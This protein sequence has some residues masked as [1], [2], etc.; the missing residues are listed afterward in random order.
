MPTPARRPTYPLLRTTQL[1]LVV[2]AHAS[3]A[4]RE[5]VDAVQAELSGL[6]A[7]VAT[8]VTESPDEWIDVLGGDVERRVVLVG[9]DGTLHS[10]VNATETRYELAL[11][12]AGRAN[13]VARSLGI[14]LTPADAARLA[15]EG[16]ARPID[17][18]EAVTPNA[19]HV[20]VE[21]VSLGFLANARSHYRGENSGNVASALTA[22][23]H[24]FAAF[25]PLAVRLTTDSLVEEL[26]A[27][28]VFIANLPLYAFGL[29]VAPGADPVDEL[30]DV[31]A[32]EARE[33]RAIVPMLME[34][35]HGDGSRLRR[36]SAIV[37]I[38]TR[39]PATIIADSYEL[40][41]GPLEVRVLPKQL[42]IVR[43]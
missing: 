36:R 35:R 24:A 27:V 4:R 16:R 29:H 33:R 9:G 2:N 40:G 6:G 31:V 21:A 12:P 7:G 32:F 5:L 14:P 8:L 13:N 3:G 39:P 26:T 11:V 30:L 28:Q 18:A 20:T 34:L 10:A 43:P 17:L 23:V 25:E 1:V 42:P 22:G 37:A 15:V 41:S 38:E 19:R